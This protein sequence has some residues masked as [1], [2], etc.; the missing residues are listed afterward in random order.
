MSADVRLLALHRPLPT[1]GDAAARSRAWDAVAG[2]TVRFPGHDQPRVAAAPG[3]RAALTPAMLAA[4][5]A[6]A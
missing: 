3:S 6:L 2:A 4:H 5:A 1:A